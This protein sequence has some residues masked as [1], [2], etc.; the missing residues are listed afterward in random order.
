VRPHLGPPRELFVRRLESNRH[1]AMRQLATAMTI[2][3]GGSMV[4]I[5][6]FA[7]HARVGWRLVGLIAGGAAM[8][9]AWGFKRPSRRNVVG[10]LILTWT[11]VVAAFALQ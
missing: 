9:V 3:T 10:L 8:A 7:P 4:A 1:R 5:A 11:V 6:M 2:V